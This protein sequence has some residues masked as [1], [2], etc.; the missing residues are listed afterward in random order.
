MIL[1]FA[2][3]TSNYFDLP[4]WNQFISRGGEGSATV[5][6]QGFTKKLGY[7]W[8][9]VLI[10]IVTLS[11]VCAKLS[12]R[13]IMKSFPH[14]LILGVIGTLVAQTYIGVVRDRQNRDWISTQQ[15]AKENSKVGEGFLVDVGL[16]IYDS[17]GTLS[18]RARVI[19]NSKAGYA[20]FYSE[21][22]NVFNSRLDKIA[23]NQYLNSVDNVLK[24]QAEFKFAYIVTK[25]PHE[26]LHFNLCY[27][28]NSYSI[29]KIKE[30]C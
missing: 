28:N 17:W 5:I 7:W 8:P 11:I 24:M 27:R 16:N 4:T 12:P 21:E 9:L 14:I 29:Y 2:T 10:I 15:W 3:L 26:S 18:Q 22:D 25:E 20:Y 1:Y 13:R 6:G 30:K 23:E 19:S